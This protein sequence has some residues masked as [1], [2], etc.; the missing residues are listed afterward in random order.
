MLKLVATPVHLLLAMGSK[1]F[2]EEQPFGCSVQ[3][4]R[5]TNL[6]FEVLLPFYRTR[7]RHFPRH[8]FAFR[9]YL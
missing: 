9:Q 1:V 4:P 8:S 3:V 7:R 2:E 5:Y 6:I